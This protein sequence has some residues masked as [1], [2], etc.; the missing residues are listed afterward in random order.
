MNIRIVRADV[1]SIKVDAMICPSAEGQI[2]TSGGN[3][4]C[5]FVISV[6]RPARGDD[7][8]WKLR[9]ATVAALEKAEEL[10]VATVALPPFWT[11]DHDLCARVMMA[12]VRDFSERARSLQRVVF[13]PIGENAHGSFERAAGEAES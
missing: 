5:R 1:M 9:Q 6:P 3:L 8:Q 12:A 11:T 4:L 13:L 7:E 10:A 2:E